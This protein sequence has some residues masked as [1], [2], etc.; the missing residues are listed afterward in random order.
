MFP[1]GFKLNT[2]RWLIYAWESW[3][4]LQAVSRE[5]NRQASCFTR[6]CTLFT[7][8][9][10]CCTETVSNWPPYTSLLSYYQSA[11]WKHLWVWIKLQLR[12]AAPTSSFACACLFF[13]SFS[14]WVL[15]LRNC[16]RPRCEITLKMFTP[17]CW[18][19]VSIFVFCQI[20]STIVFFFHRC[21]PGNAPVNACN[22]RLTI[23]ASRFCV[24]QNR[25]QKVHR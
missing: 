25:S 13:F 21:Q 17:E 4:D 24:S 8:S 5:R 3:D 20:Y 11:H 18:K 1:S 12:L 23:R 14:G 19:S 2:W 9:S 22:V 16:L 15:I 7:T 10:S 6:R